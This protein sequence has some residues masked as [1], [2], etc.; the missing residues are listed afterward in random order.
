MRAVWVLVGVLLLAVSGQAVAE[1]VSH[2]GV[3]IDD[4]DDFVMAWFNSATTADFALTIHRRTALADGTIQATTILTTGISNACTP[5]DTRDHVSCTWTTGAAGQNIFIWK[6]ASSGHVPGNYTIFII[7]QT[8]LGQP[9]DRHVWSV[10][11]RPNEHLVVESRLNATV[12][13]TVNNARLNLV[14]HIADHHATQ[15]HSH[16][17][18]GL[19]DTACHTAHRDAVTGHIDVHNA[20]QDHSHAP[21]PGHCDTDCHNAHRDAVLDAVADGVAT[22]Q[23]GVPCSSNCG[24][25][26]DLDEIRINVAYMNTTGTLCRANCSAVD[27]ASLKAMGINVDDALPGGLTVGAWAVVLLWFLAFIWCAQNRWLLPAVWAFVGMLI[28]LVV[29][30]LDFTM[31][32]TLILFL[33]SIVLTWAADAFKLGRRAAVDDS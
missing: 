22:I 20:T 33:V 27:E 30:G 12:N 32:A 23:Q 13:A 17:V 6:N 2:G 5:V 8:N 7:T 3:S 15:D 18:P 10:R 9:V 1:N 28:P 11:I 14:D 4:A 29:E 19:C 16:S 21:G 24:G 25:T 26:G 31:T